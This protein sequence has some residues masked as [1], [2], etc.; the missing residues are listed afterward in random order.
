VGTC[1]YIVCLFVCVICVFACVYIHKQIYTCLKQESPPGVIYGKLSY[2][3]AHNSFQ[4]RGLCPG[5]NVVVRSLT[6]SLIYEYGI[7]GKGKSSSLHSL[8]GIVYLCTHIHPI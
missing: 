5:L 2:E 7:G 3:Y 1:V 4:S 8:H 6:H